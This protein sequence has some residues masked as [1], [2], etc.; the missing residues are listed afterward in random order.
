MYKCQ[1]CGKVT[2]PG[3]KLNK[4]V[5]S[6][7]EKTYVNIMI[8]KKTGNLLKDKSG[9]TIEKITKGF[10]TNREENLCTK[11]F[12]FKKPFKKETLDKFSNIKKNNDKLYNQQYLGKFVEN[13]N[14]T[15][16]NNIERKYPNSNYQGK[17]FDPDY[18]KKKYANQERKERA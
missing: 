14:N 11:C 3:E 5:T 17:N 10:E 2:D 15:N 9:N 12:E 1:K 13:K 18:Y 8:D 6:T 16:E 4:L 7:R